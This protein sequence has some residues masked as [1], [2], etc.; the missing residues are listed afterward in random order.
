MSPRHASCPCAPRCTACLRAY[1]PA[2]SQ[3]SEKKLRVAELGFA[4]LG[5]HVEHSNLREI[6]VWLRGGVNVVEISLGIPR[7]RLPMRLKVGAGGT[8]TS[9][10]GD[11]VPAMSL[12]SRMTT[13]KPKMLES[14]QDSRQFTILKPESE[15]P[16]VLE[17]AQ[18]SSSCAPR[19]CCECHPPAASTARRE[20]S[21]CHNAGPTPLNCDA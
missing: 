21:S 13:G 7:S 12:A 19:T 4:E 8:Y 6:R 1:L 15:A 3:A 20:T 9:A 17:C 14:A 2:I 11:S 18:T 16:I 10:V 5:T